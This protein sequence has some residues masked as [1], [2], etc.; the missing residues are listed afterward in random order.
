MQ[1]PIK[2]DSPATGKGLAQDGFRFLNCSF[3]DFRAAVEATNRAVDEHL[4]N[5]LIT[6]V[7]KYYENP[8]I[9]ITAFLKFKSIRSACGMIVKMFKRTGDWQ[10]LT[11][12]FTDWAKKQNTDDPETLEG[13]IRII[14]NAKQ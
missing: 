1:I 12:D 3:E 13:I 14:Y 6:Y 5:L 2:K 7:G 8:K 11:G 9:F 4:T 10:R